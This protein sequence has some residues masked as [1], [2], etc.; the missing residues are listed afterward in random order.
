MGLANKQQD[1][2]RAA[3]SKL[4]ELPKLFRVQTWK[5][6]KNFSEVRT[7]LNSKFEFQV[8]PSL[9]ENTRKLLI[10]IVDH[11]SFWIFPKL[12]CML[13]NM[14][15]ETSYFRSYK[16]IF[17]SDLNLIVLFCLFSEFQTRKDFK[18]KQRMSKINCKCIFGFFQ[19]LKVCSEFT[20]KLSGQPETTRTC[21][22]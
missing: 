9:L 14:L 13:I 18:F 5:Y 2:V 15:R 12:M 3:N 19:V 22:S 7:Y 20:W 17:L 10:L 16:R 4:L 11:Q 6:L 8:F 21:F 1:V